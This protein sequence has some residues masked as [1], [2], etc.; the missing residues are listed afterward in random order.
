MSKLLGDRLDSTCQ[1]HG[2]TRSQFEVMAVL[3]RH[4]PEPLSAGDLMNAAFLTSGS[5][6][7]L[8]DQLQQKGWIVR[9]P[10]PGDRRRLDVRLTP[11]GIRII[12]PA[13][14]ER[15]SDNSQIASLVPP[16]LRANINQAMREILSILESST[17]NQVRS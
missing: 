9:Q 12:E 7:S 10:T 14:I 15:I 5:V 1:R 4:D 3:R 11:E 6:T 16:E 17:S 13:V 8:L 2:L